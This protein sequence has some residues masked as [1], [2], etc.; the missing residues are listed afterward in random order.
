MHLLYL[1]NQCFNIETVR[2]LTFTWEM[3]TSISAFE[4]R[5]FSSLAGFFAFLKYFCQHMVIYIFY[6]LYI[7]AVAVN[8]DRLIILFFNLLVRGVHSTPCFKFTE[9]SA[10]KQ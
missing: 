8:I 7:F 6:I 1:E 5:I 4:M 10:V 2:L 9:R 3:T